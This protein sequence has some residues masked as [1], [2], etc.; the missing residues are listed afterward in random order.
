[1]SALYLL[2]YSPDPFYIYTSYQGASE[3]VSHERFYFFFQ[4]KEIEV[5]TNSLNL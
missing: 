2:Q 3:G 5:F 4:I 1:M